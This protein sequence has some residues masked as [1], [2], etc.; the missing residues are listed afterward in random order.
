MLTV[1][2]RSNPSVLNLVLIVIFIIAIVVYAIISL[3]TGD[4]M[5]F[6]NRFA[7]TPNGV[8]VHCFGNSIEFDPGSY[9]FGALA[10]IMN[11]T[12]SGQKRYDP[13]SMSLETYQ[14]YQQ[15]PG[16]VTI[17]FFYPAAIR[18]HSGYKF[19]SSVDNLVVPLEGRHAQ[20]KAVFGQNQGVPTAGSLHVDSTERLKEYLRN[21]KICQVATSSQ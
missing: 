18:V 17:E 1:G 19:F 8:I 16:M 2:Q 6:S 13:L 4:W 21:Q 10:E 7:E 11:E 15:H 12:M 3:S 20:T 14:D 9:H 5:W